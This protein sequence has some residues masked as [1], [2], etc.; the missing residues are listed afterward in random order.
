[1]T[2]TRRQ[3]ALARSLTTQASAALLLSSAGLALAEVPSQ[4]SSEH[5]DWVPAEALTPEQRGLTRRHCCGAYVSPIRDD[6]DALLDPSLAPIRASADNSNIRQETR[7]ELIGDVEL[8]QGY[9][10][11]SADR[12]NYDQETGDTEAFGNIEIREPGLL[13]KASEASMQQDGD[14]VQ[15]KDAEFVIHQVHI[16]GQANRLE[17]I[18]NEFIRMDSSRFTSCAPDDN[19]WSVSGA[20]I[21][22]HPE[23]NYGTARHARLNIKDVP[24]LYTPYVRFPVGDDRL[25]GFLFPSA[26]YSRRNGTEITVPFYWNIA[27]QADMT[28]TPQYM[29]RRGTLWDVETRHLSRYFETDL[30]GAYLNNDRGGYNRRLDNQIADGE[31]TEEEAYP[32]RGQA[33]WVYQI[34]QTGGGG[35]QRWSTQIDYTELSDPDYLRDLDAGALDANRQARVSKIASAN[36]R[37]DN[38]LFGIRGEEERTLS[39]TT[40]QEPYRELPRINLDGNYRLPGDL[41]VE[42]D[43]EFTRFDVNDYFEEDTDNLILGERLRTDYRVSWDKDWNWGFFKPGVGYRTLNYDL[44]PE[45]L[46]E[47]ANARPSL[48]AAQ[49]SLDMGLVFERFG[50]RY[51]QTLEPRAFYFYSELEDHSELF[52]ITANNRNVDFDTREPTFGYNQLYRTSRFTGGDRIDD[53]DQWTLGLT[54]RFIDNATGIERASLGVGRIFYNRDREINRRGRPQEEDTL[55]KSD[56]ATR[57]Q[58]RVGDHLQLT[59]D[60]VYNPGASQIE[61]G[62][63]SV[64]YFDDQARIANLSYRFNRRQPVPDRLDPDSFLDRSL[65]QVDATVHW[66]IAGGWSVIGRYNYDLT[67]N[68]ELYVFA[69]LEYD[70]CCYRIRVV[71]RRWLDFDYNPD[72]LA[73][74][75]REDYDEGIVFDIQFKGLGSINERITSMLGKAIPGYEAREKAL[76]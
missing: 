55:D 63:L 47:D 15:L 10:S 52:E 69:G 31:I 41:L 66:P 42:L 21:T 60:L 54:S 73:E 33:R 68:R 11:L 38:W 71:A 20:R 8:Y 45:A 16:R 46:T 17:R 23:K 14:N 9:R 51:T 1:M 56:I 30:S 43:N 48:D 19:T 6:D 76:H 22:L 37:A 7:I 61:S 2:L 49:T 75:R 26:S 64:R 13:L 4:P 25:T 53:A 62:S 50:S 32:Y 40:R 70:D 36:Y 58:A 59:N 65:D 35:E 24:T 5:L 74:V 57:L 67:Y 28:I 39:V 29:S 27:P 12:L 34:D 44:K 3:A 18:G 72:L